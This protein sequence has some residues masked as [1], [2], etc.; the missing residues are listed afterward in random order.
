L[1][2]LA[3]STGRGKNSEEFLGSTMAFWAGG[4]GISHRHWPLNLKGD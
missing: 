2:W 1:W 3:G 4:R